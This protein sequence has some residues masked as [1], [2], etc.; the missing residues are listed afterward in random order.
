MDFFSKAIFY[1]LPWIDAEFPIELVTKLLCAGVG[2]ELVEHIA[3]ER[4][5]K[6]VIRDAIFATLLF[7]IDRVVGHIGGRSVEEI[8][9]GA[10]VGVK[11]VAVQLQLLTVDGKACV[12]RRIQ[13]RRDNFF[14]IVVNFRQLVDK[15]PNLL[16]I[17]V[18]SLGRAPVSRAGWM[19]CLTVGLYVL[20][21]VDDFSRWMGRRN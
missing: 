6:G 8:W 12:F 4:F 20:G 17:V 11:S 10:G 1:A 21:H 19:S 15:I 2:R 18:S 5:F 14:N 7:H 9:L 3:L 13:D 16:L